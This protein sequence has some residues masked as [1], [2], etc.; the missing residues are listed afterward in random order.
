MA[1]PFTYAQTILADARNGVTESPT[2]GCTFKRVQKK[3][4]TNY[5]WIVP[6]AEF[7]GENQ[8]TK[9]MTIDIA[10]QSRSLFTKCNFQT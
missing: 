2:H 4:I 8:H 3:S 10:S 7:E 9:N 1:Y 6:D 5:E